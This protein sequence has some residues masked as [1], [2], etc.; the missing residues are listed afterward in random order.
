MYPCRELMPARLPRSHRQRRGRTGVLLPKS[1]IPLANPS[2]NPRPD[3]YFPQG[4]LAQRLFHLPL[5]KIQSRRQPLTLIHRVT[6]TRQPR[7]MRQVT[8]IRQMMWIRQAKLIRR[9][10]LMH[11]R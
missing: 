7:L 8:L 9:G 6:L 3:L 5:P 4:H 10:T 1:Q 11:Q 2:T